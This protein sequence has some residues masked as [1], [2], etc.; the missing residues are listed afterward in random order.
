MKGHARV[1]WDVARPR[2]HGDGMAASAETE[3]ELGELALHAPH[4]ADVVGDDRHLARGCG[5]CPGLG[6]V[7]ELRGRPGSH[8]IGLKD[9]WI[10]PGEPRL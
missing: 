5:L 2:D 9:Y 10:G 1:G 6:G 3:D 7:G 8:R 4:R